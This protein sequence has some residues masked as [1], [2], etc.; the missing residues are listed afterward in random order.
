MTRR[1]A[2]AALAATLATG[3]P[4]QQ[5]P[6]PQLRAIWVNSWNDGML[7]PEQVEQMVRDVRSANLNAVVVEVRKVGDAYYLGG[8]EP[9]ASNIQGPEDWDP[10]QQIIDL[11]HDTSGGQQRIEVHAWMVTFRVWRNSLGAPPPGH[12]LHEHPEVVMTSASGD[13]DGEGSVFA[14]P[15]HPITED[16][17]VAVYRDVAARYDVDGVHF[18][19]VRY[20]EYEGDWGHNPVSIE[21]F[22]RRNSLTGVPASG[23]PR[24]QAWRREQVR[25]TVR[26]VYGEVMEANPG[27]LVSAS[28][29]NW[30]L[31][32]SVWDWPTSRPRLQ[33]HQDWVSFM[34]EGILDL[35]CLMNYSRFVTQP[36]RFPTYTDLAIRTRLDRH[37]I[38]GAGV[39]MN[40]VEHGFTQLR[41]A[42]AMGADGVLLY[43]YGTTNNEDLPRDAYF[44]RLRA[45]VFP[46]R[47]DV[48]ARLWRSRPNTGA[49]IGQVFDAQ[50]NWV[51]GA[52]VTLDGVRSMV[53]D[54]T[55]FYG[56]FRVDPGPHTVQVTMPQAARRVTGEGVIVEPGRA[57]RFDVGSARDR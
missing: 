6:R 51:D 11:C 26:R 38:I 19:Y 8:L 33:A 46:T 42:L 53:T 25:A 12:L 31:E 15:G 4:A 39:Y 27:C 28:T 50:G 49:V 10:L 22:N 55:G 1:I 30:G 47:A 17:T 3:A 16:W 48:P 56:F 37:A 54:G 13:A 24:W 43:D 5:E 41:Q 32:T 14:D 40:T 2:L 35:N 57:A 21:R 18:D 20:P 36:L 29:L 7:S 45:E 44:A 9:R 23:D 52:T 34:D